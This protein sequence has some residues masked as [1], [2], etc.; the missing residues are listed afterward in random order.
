MI[1][2]KR[3]LLAF[4]LFFIL[5]VAFSIESLSLKK[6]ANREI[7]EYVISQEL[8]DRIKDETDCISDEHHIIQ[9]SCNLTSKLLK[10]DRRNDIANGKANCI[11][12]AQLSSAI[13]NYA[14][15][16]HGLPYKARPVVGQVYCFGINLTA[17]SQKILP[18]KYRP[19]FKDHDFVEVDL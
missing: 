7:A 3:I 15:K 17:L 18:A 2:I 9:Y 16:L 1:R 10:F 4:V 11:G 19:F 13:I 5:F 12:Y 8:K 14:F 6:T